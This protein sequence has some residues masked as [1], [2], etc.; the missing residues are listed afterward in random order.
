MKETL[1]FE[2][3]ELQLRCWVEPVISH[4]SAQSALC[5]G[6]GWVQ[7]WVEN[8]F[9]SPQVLYSLGVEVS[10]VW[11]SQNPLPSVV[12]VAVVA[13][14]WWR[15]LGGQ[16]GA[17]QNGERRFGAEHVFLSLVRAVAEPFNIYEDYNSKNQHIY[18]TYCACVG[19]SLS[20]LHRFA[21]LIPINNL[22]GM[23]YHRWY[24]HHHHH[25]YHHHPIFQMRR[26]V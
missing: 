1:I 25:Y 12:V 4:F 18:T 14:V 17:V 22:N 11:G 7:M 21:L 3:W 19:Y 20:T 5:L 15:R 9:S 8:V 6:L 24:H 23:F 16:G 13:V 26:Q 10:V 2:H